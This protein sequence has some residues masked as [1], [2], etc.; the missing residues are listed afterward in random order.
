MRSFSEWH[1]SEPG[2]KNLLEHCKG[3]IRSLMP[4]ATVILYGSRARGEAKA[5]SDYDLL[6]LSDGDVPLAL[7]EKIENALYDIELE[8]NAVIPAFIFERKTWGHSRFKAL[9]LHQNIDRE[10]VVL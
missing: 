7:E 10:G 9:P 8:R 4:E 3:V 2:E 5:A 1:T 6:I